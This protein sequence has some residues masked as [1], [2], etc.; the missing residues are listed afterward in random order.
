[1]LY[2][3]GL[4]REIGALT[5]Q[6]VVRMLPGVWAMTQFDANRKFMQA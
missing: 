3:M 1:M 6:Y 5:Q 2:Y 4:D